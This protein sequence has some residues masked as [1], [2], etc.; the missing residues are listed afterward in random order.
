MTKSKGNNQKIILSRKEE[1]LIMMIRDKYRFGEMTILIQ[2]G[3]PMDLL[4]TRNRI[5]LGK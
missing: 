3:V 4:I 2:D 5:R 1:Q